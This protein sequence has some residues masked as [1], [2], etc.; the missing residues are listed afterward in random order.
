[1]FSLRNKINNFQLRTLIWGPGI[2]SICMYLQAD[3]KIVESNKLASLKPSDMDVHYSKT[4][5]KQPQKKK[6]KN[7]FLRPIIV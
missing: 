2:T 7:C 1:M 4:C 3:W 6:T 5:L